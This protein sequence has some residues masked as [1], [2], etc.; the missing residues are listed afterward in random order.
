MAYTEDQ[1]IALEQALASGALT[2]EYADRRITYRSIDDLKKAIQVVKA[3]LNSGTINEH[4]TRSVA[5]TSKG[6]SVG[7]GGSWDWG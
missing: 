3:E 4:P 5:K 6:Y 7:G 1:L 2:V